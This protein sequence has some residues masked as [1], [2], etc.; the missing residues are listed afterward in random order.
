MSAAADPRTPARRFGIGCGL[1]AV[2]VASASFAMRPDFVAA[3]VSSDGSLQPYTLEWL[4]TYRTIA[5]VG[6][7]LIAGIGI[8]SFAGA[9]GLGPAIARRGALLRKLGVA[10]VATGLALLGLEFT[11]RAV[12]SRDDVVRERHDFEAAARE[13]M[14]RVQPQLNAD[15]FRDDAFDRPR[16]DG[17]RRVLVIGDSFAFGFGIDDRSRTFPA[18]LE[19]ELS[20]TQPTDVFNAGV[21]GADCRRELD[22]LGATIDRVDPDL[23]LIA[24]YVND[25]ESNECKQEYVQ[26]SRL[27][28]LVSDVL[29]RHSALWRRLEPA[30]VALCVRCGA[31][32]SY[33]DHLRRLHDVPSGAHWAQREAFTAMLERAGRDGRR[34][35]VL[36]FPLV[37]AFDD[38]PLAEVH[39]LLRTT[40]A[41]SGVP[42]CDLYVA[43]CHET[44]ESLQTSALDHHLNEKGCAL[45]ARA[46]ASFI[47]EATLLPP[48]AER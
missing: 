33:L 18:A 19:A 32:A 40:C 26:Q 16:A 5:I 6:A 44:A 17:E 15:G 30:L 31:K 13:F 20:V 22:V 28:P 46:A 29:L 7:V 38:H 9:A 43:L 11:L 25:A 39:A 2:A 35:A 10:A 23:V 47:H 45:A 1:V 37:E 4:A 34:V 3:R 21:P 27:I 48:A 42:C 8:A 41:Q 12:E 36:L 24:W 14:R